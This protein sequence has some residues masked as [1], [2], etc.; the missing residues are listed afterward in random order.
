LWQEYKASRKS[1]GIDALGSVVVEVELQV[2]LS[3]GV[4]VTTA[5][6][7]VTELVGRTAWLGLASASVASPRVTLSRTIWRVSLKDR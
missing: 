6:G 7:A 2:G 1:W 3:D 4:V 5:D